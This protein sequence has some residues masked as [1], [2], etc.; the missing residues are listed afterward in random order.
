M[1]T[2]KPVIQGGGP[3]YLGKQKM[4]TAPKKWK[5]SPTHPEAHL[6]YITDEEQDLLIKKNLYGS[7]KGK[8]NRGPSGIVSLQGDLG[9]Y[10]ASPGGA[11]N[12]GGG[13]GDNE[14]QNRAAEDAARTR[15]VLTGKIQKDPS[16]GNWEAGRNLGRRESL[17]GIGLGQNIGRSIRSDLGGRRSRMGGILGALGRGALSFFGGIPGKLMSGIM[18]AK[19]WA[20]NKGTGFMKGVGEFAEYDEEGN[21]MYP[22][23]DRFINRNTGKYDD[24]PYLGQGQS[25]YTFN[26]QDTARDV[27]Y[28]EK[29]S[30]TSFSD[31]S[32]VKPNNQFV[33]EEQSP[34]FEKYNPVYPTTG[35]GAAEGGRIGYERGRVVNPG[36]YQGEEEGVDSVKHAIILEQM[37]KLEKMIASGL[38]SD[39]RLQARLDQLIATPTTGLGTGPDLVLPDDMAQGGIARLL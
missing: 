29:I 13:G 23:W 11:N 27:I 24:K 5:S 14:A 38:D 7:L 26:D 8:P 2:K 19:N 31:L 15:A 39:G 9:G 10:D 33:E 16:T 25:N 6:A 3:N 36:G 37:D 1:A 35:L 34:F 22:T 20:K 12:Q 4:V 17:A 30:D 21:P 32:G 18:T 28:P